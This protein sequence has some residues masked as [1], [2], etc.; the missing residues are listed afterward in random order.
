MQNR[1]IVAHKS[2]LVRP[3]L[4]EALSDEAHK[5]WVNSVLSPIFVQHIVL[6]THFLSAIATFLLRLF[7]HSSPI[8]LRILS[9]MASM[10]LGRTEVFQAVMVK[11]F[12]AFFAT[13]IVCLVYR[14]SKSIIF[15]SKQ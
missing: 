1:A 2:C 11:D 15:A 6:S 10:R 7:S 3:Y 4:T 12:G 9:V 13:H 8:L 5:M 14:A